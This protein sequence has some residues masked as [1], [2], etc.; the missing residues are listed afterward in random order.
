MS[1]DSEAEAV[2][3]CIVVSELHEN[4]PAEAE[5]QRSLCYPVSA[6]DRKA[7]VW[8]PPL[9][10]DDACRP[11]VFQSGSVR[12]MNRFCWLLAA[13]TF[14]AHGAERIFDFSDFPAGFRSTVAGNGPAG[15]W[16]VVMDEVP[17]QLAPLTDKAPVVTKRAVLAQLSQDMTD[18]RFPLLIFEGESFMDFTLTTRFKM[19]SGVA[20]Q[21]AGVAFRIQDEKNFYVVRAS[22]RSNN[23]RFYKV[24]NGERGN[25]IGPEIKV[26][27]GV[28]H[29]L[30]VE[31][32]GNQIRCQ[33]NGK[34]VIPPLTDS[35]F[36]GGKIGF[37][38]KSD[39]VSYFTEAKIVYTA[40]EP[41]AQ[42]LV[43]DAL[44]KYP[45]LLGLKIYAM[46]GTPPKLQVVGSND[47]KEIGQPG[48]RAEQDVLDRGTMYYAK[49][50][51]TVAVTMPLRDRNGDA[52][53]AVRVTMQ[54][55]PGQTEQNAI[56]RAAPIVK[57]M[58]GRFQKW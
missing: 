32:K 15:D 3:R 11:A 26:P 23:F 8:T 36:P 55:F 58:Q 21:M 2:K 31:C 46:R 29:D 34:E 17:P 20:E 42:V 49:G 56:I 35:T 38:T 27:Q 1:L 40:R 24:A 6:F 37:W 22:A 53:A 43:R 13:L 33:L 47:E 48:A 50:K 12:M 52:V 25:L 14:S 4:V 28:W 41:L 45:R 9:H 30:T 7:E 5:L 51:G 19:V 57:Q 18:E 10:S 39:S 44:K 54:S 16:K